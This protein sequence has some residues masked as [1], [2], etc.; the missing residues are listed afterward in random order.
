[1][2]KIYHNTRCK[3]SR[4]VLNFLNENKL[5]FEV[6]EYLKKSPTVEELKV[7]LIKLHILPFDLLRKNEKLFK[8]KFKGKRF[9]DNEW[10]QI[11]HENPILIQRPI[12]VHNNKA[13]ICNPPEK[14]LDILKITI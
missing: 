7:L 8:E 6:V 3:I 14:V 1:M 9:T 10:L 2:L 4:S 11:I 12:V 13:V 5:E